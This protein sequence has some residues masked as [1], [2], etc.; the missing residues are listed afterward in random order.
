MTT[1][2]KITSALAVLGFLFGVWRHFKANG[3]RG[4]LDAVI[5]GAEHYAE[6]S[7]E[8][9]GAHLK[10]TIRSFAQNAGVDA[11]LH[12]E[13][14]KV[15]EPPAVAPPAAAAGLLA[16]L[17]VPAFL[18]GGCSLMGPSSEEWQA[19][20]MT[21]EQAEQAVAQSDALHRQSLDQFRDLLQAEWFAAIDQAAIDERHHAEGFVWAKGWTPENPGAADGKLTADEAT[22]IAEEVSALK[23]D[24][25]ATIARAYA[26]GIDPKSRRDLREVL[27]S[28]KFWI[29]ARAGGA[30][31]TEEVVGRLRDAAKGAV[32]G[33]P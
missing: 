31:V 9:Q 4:A 29:A 14:K 7:G 3:W 11:V 23:I 16:L 26:A 10:S 22:A 30:K 12:E 6:N 8:G 13:V 17:L 33:G 21:V 20:T 25:L 15:T 28:L 1:Y 24:A 32:T 18:L 27:G 19:A 5:A 2:E